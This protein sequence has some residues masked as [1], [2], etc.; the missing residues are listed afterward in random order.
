MPKPVLHP[1]LMVI[2][3]SV[4][5]GCRSLSVTRQF[6]AQS[7]PATLARL[8]DLGAFAAPRHP[9][10]VL[11]DLEAIASDLA[12]QGLRI[13]LG[14]IGANYASWL[15]DFAAPPA[16]RPVTFDNLAIAGSTLEDLT[17]EDANPRGE[18][19]VGTP[20]L[21]QRF[22]ASL[23]RLDVFT[24]ADRDR[25][26]AAHLAVN[27]R[28]V[29]NPSNDPE[30]TDWSMLDWVR[31]RQPRTLILHA[32]H[33]NGFYKIGSEGDVALWRAQWVDGARPALARYLAVLDRIEAECPDTRLVVLGLPK[34]GAVSNLM[35][36]RD[37]GPHPHDP[38]YWATYYSVFPSPRRVD[39]TLVK[40]TDD[41]VRDVN[42]AL[43]RAVAAN[44]HRRERW[45]Y[46]SVYGFF[47]R[48]DTKN[49]GAARESLKF[50]RV[51]LTN[52]F[53]DAERVRQPGPPNRPP[54]FRW[55]FVDGGF[56]SID[57]MHPSLVGYTLLAC[58]LVGTLTG[59]PLSAAARKRALDEAF[60]NERLIQAFPAGLK[61][62][63]RKVRKTE[64]GTPEDP[65]DEALGGV[66][67]R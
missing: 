53:L 65:D 64:E 4:A 14:G 66:V 58:E 18:P 11:F 57:G 34:I 1:P 7:Y 52:N 40:E 5:Q 17:G 63:L 38:G 26:G 51:T 59:R 48:Y 56:Q 39:G 19:P 61:T 46:F 2:G 20:A 43:A 29:L 37:E 54:K 9:R 67:R 8:A 24:R 35:P 25:I 28:Y 32:G 15:A 22:L 60:D 3:D 55:E 23:P 27:A 6:C 42:D 47:D 16:G 30:Y 36:D 49:L 62:I 33:N 31:L 13:V 21:A 45:T 41:Q 50:R 12:G 44:A 10:A